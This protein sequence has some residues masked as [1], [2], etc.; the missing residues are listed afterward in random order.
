MIFK[1]LEPSNKKD[2]KYMISFESPDKIIHFGSKKS[3]TYL[4]HHDKIKRN[5]YIK[6]HKVN[7]DWNDPLSAGALSLYILW[8]ASTNLNKNLHYYLNHFNISY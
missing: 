8:G 4:D 3:M 5:N 6:R 2:K 7:E 1:N